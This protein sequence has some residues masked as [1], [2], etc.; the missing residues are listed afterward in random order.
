VKIYCYQLPE[1]KPNWRQEIP[2]SEYGYIVV[3]ICS[4][5]A[6]LLLPQASDAG[7]TTPIISVRVGDN[8]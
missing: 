6:L 1:L 5:S 2:S 7:E 4:L 8:Q 3:E